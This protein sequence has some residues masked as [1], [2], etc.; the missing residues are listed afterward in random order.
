MF[1]NPVIINLLHCQKPTTT[2]SACRQTYRQP[3]GQTDRR[4]DRPTDKQTNKQ[5][6]PYQNSCNQTRNQRRVN[7]LIASGSHT[8]SF[9]YMLTT[10]KHAIQWRWRRSNEKCC[11]TSKAKRGDRKLEKKKDALHCTMHQVCCCRWHV[12]VCCL[13]S[14]CIKCAA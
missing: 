13:A 6:V 4:T 7:C 11:T 2:Y 3:D 12:E 9:E 10:K 5:T 8:R 14:I 1:T